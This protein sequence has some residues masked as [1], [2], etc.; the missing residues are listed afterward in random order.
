MLGHASIQMTL[1]TYGHMFEKREQQLTAKLD[2]RARRTA[3]RFAAS[4]PPEGSGGVV[5]LG[6]ARAGHGA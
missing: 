1:G 4:L 6:A 5:S 2:A 3:A